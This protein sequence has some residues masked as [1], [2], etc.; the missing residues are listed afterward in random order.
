M[1]P[2]RTPDSLERYLNDFRRRRV[3]VLG[4]A[5]LDEYLLGEC[6]RLSPE[7]PVPV[8]RVTR[9]RHVLGGAA[10]TAANIVSL[11]ARATLISFVGRDPAGDSLRRCASAAGIQLIPV[12]HGSATL[13]KTRVVGQHQ[14]IVRL[15]YEEIPAPSAT[16]EAEIMEQFERCVEHCDVVV[17]SDYA[18]GFVSAGLA[19]AVLR[20]AHAAGCRV[21]I[22]PRPQH[23]D[24]YVGCDY[25]TPNW[26]EARALLNLDDAEPAPSEVRAVAQA[27][28]A[29]LNTNVVLTLGAHGIAYCGAGE[30][31]SLPTLAREV[32]DVSGAG[33]TVVAAL[34]LGIASGADPRIVLSLANRAASIVVGKFGTATVT[35]DE[36]LQDT[37]HRRLVPQ[38]ALE[39]L[40]ATLRAKG[41]RI[42]TTSGDFNGL[43]ASHLSVLDEARRSGDVLIAG[44]NG[45]V[46]VTSRGGD[47]RQIL[48]ERSR[49]DLLLALRMVDYV[50]ILNGGSVAPLLRDLQPDVHVHWAEAGEPPAQLDEARRYCP[51]IRIVSPLATS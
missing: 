43:L 18:K 38:H 2:S 39:P 7:A 36:I 3:V 26:K 46:T 23:R 48:S 6:S 28:R 9:S 37:S 4:D 35:P 31:F 20:R 1:Q 17:I 27:L 41:K 14:Q 15:D 22:D 16:L 8:V 5:I 19:R 21:V 11:G 42:V 29:A 51:T 47:T 13:R 33:D 44:V 12:D 32:F 24:C 45:D 10:N 40:A 50:H 25:L 49:A 30:E 34:A